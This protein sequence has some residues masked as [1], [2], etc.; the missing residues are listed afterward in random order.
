MIHCRERVFIVNKGLK[1]LKD[2]K[3]KSDLRLIIG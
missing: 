3:T 1:I 2:L